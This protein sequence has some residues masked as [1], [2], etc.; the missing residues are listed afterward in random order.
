MPVYL[1]ATLV[2]FAFA[3]TVL[4]HPVFH[5]DLR[6][7]LARRGPTA[8]KE[9]LV[10]AAVEQ[11]SV[12]IP[13]R[14]EA[15][16]LPDLL[17][18]LAAQGMMPH[19]IIV[20][21][22]QSEDATA[23]IAGRH[24]ARVIRAGDR[25]SGWLGKPWASSVGA[26]AA[27]GR[28]LLFLDADVQLRPE[29]LEMLA[30]AFI[31]VCPRWPRS[32]ATIS[33]QPYHRTGRYVERLALLFN[34]LVFV[35]AAKRT[36]G[37]LLTMDGCCCFGPSILCGRDDYL[38]FGGHESIR[39]SVVDDL[40]LGRQFVRFAVPVRSFSGRGVVD[41]RMYPGGF[42]DLLDGFTKN[43]L[44]GA[45]RSGRW[46]QVLAVLWITGLI[47]A[48][49]YIAMAASVG[50]VS[51]LVIALVFYTFFAI[52]FAAAGHRL[53]NFGPLPALIF[54]VH[55]FVFLFVLARSLLLAVTGRNVRW[56]GRDLTIDAEP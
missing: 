51:E 5:S 35:G 7:Y 17:D 25:P 16:V 15:E 21:D 11:I 41:F 13:A 28:L 40:D 27:K 45:R 48:P 50:V 55:L 33:V 30:R 26:G 53:G 2:L 44:L 34:I 39:D 22:D 18:T 24:G 4:L 32:L 9:D 6:G 23:A 12:V 3:G 10:R 37:L 49:L 47:A 20:V 56:K 14:N 42:R 52:Q 19:E 46:F 29:A 43:I 31:S 1:L 36:R 8:A 38:A 54:P